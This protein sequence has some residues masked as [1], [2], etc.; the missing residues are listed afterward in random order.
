MDR[1]ELN[2]K[3]VVMGTK[4]DNMQLYNYIGNNHTILSQMYKLMDCIE[5]VLQPSAINLFAYETISL[6]ELTEYIDSIDRL[7][8]EFKATYNP[9]Y[10]HRLI[11]LCR[12]FQDLLKICREIILNTEY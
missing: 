3:I 1:L 11:T 12:E 2:D 10:I 8:N 5:S 6:N 7:I 4:L 9:R